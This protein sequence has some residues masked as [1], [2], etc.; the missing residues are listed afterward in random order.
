M[1][2]LLTL[3]MMTV[4]SVASHSCYSVKDIETLIMQIQINTLLLETE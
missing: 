4:L 1:M 3:L 2:L